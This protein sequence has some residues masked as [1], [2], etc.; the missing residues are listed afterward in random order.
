MELWIV[1]SLLG[2]ALQAFRV[3]GSGSWHKST[4]A[5]GLCPV[6]RPAHLV[7]LSLASGC[8]YRPGFAAWQQDTALAP[9][10]LGPHLGTFWFGCS[11]LPFYNGGNCGPNRLVS[12]R[13]FALGIVYV[14]VLI[15]AMAVIG[16]VVFNDRFSVWEWAA[17]GIGTWA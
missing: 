10:W 17:I 5:V 15:P 7:V 13:N 1:L 11:P 16:V 14:K 12:R 3:A 4:R 8:L 6:M 9:I 2:G